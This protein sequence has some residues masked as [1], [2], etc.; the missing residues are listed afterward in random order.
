ME[1]ATPAPESNPPNYLEDLVQ[2]AK[3]GDLEAQN[4]I[5]T[6]NLDCIRGLVRNRLGAK[7]KTRMEE[8]DLVQTAMIEV[9]RDIKKVD[10]R[11]RDQFFQWLAQLVHNKIRDKAEYYER[12]KRDVKRE[13]PLVPNDSTMTSSGGIP[14]TMITAKTRGPATRVEY[15]EDQER[16]QRALRELPE[17]LRT[18]IIEKQYNNRSL[19]EIAE[20]LGISEGIVARRLVKALETLR[21]SLKGNEPATG[22]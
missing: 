9:I 11:G 20:Q 14:Q 6:D 13:K 8:D 2:R 4:Q 18:I 12:Q 15:G 7:L 5:V 21:R 17:D 1:N 19:K 22:V 3:A 16:L 10:Y